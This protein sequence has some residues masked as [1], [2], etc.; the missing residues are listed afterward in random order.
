MKPEPYL[1][2]H[3]YPLIVQI[4]GG[5]ASAVRNTFPVSWAYYS[6]VF[7]SHGYAVLQPNYRGSIGRGAEFMKANVGHYFEKDIDDIITGI[8]A[9]VKRGIASPELVGVMGWSAGGHMTNWLITHPER[10]DEI[11]VTLQA[12]SSGAGVANWVSLYAQTDVQFTR[13]HYLLAPPWKNLD[14]YMQ[15]SPLV[16]VEKARTPTLILFG[17]ADERIPMPQGKEL[18]LGLKNNGVPT[19][20][21]LYP[22]EPHGLRK[23]KHQ[24]DK[25]QREFG[26]FEKYIRGRGLWK[27]KNVLTPEDLVAM[28]RVS[29]PQL[30]PDGKTVVY[31]LTETDR[32][33]NRRQSDLYRIP[34]MGGEPVRLTRHP[35]ND[36]APKWSP[37]GRRIALSVQPRRQHAGVRDESVHRR[38]GPADQN[39][40]RGVVVCLVAG[41]GVSRANRARFHH[42]RRGAGSQTET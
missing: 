10:F 9:M 13:E 2:G 31:V 17:E 33:E 4:H 40:A 12:A 20:F 32:Q 27:E 6:H 21:V 16:Y 26:W 39:Q 14:H 25:M 19:E 7:A 8:A 36:T 18:Y 5:P 35:K 1:K 37:D 22:G 29:Q 41:R 34:A 15:K 3:R 28:Q 24:L 38:A 11:G 30:S 23:P 42:A